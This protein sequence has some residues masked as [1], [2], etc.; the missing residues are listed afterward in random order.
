MKKEQEYYYP[1]LPWS[2]IKS[3]NLT[4]NKER[5][6]KTA[7]L[8]KEYTEVY[9]ELLEDQEIDPETTFSFVYFYS[10]MKRRR[11]FNYDLFPRSM[12]PPRN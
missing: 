6:T 10:M 2:L 7:K 1:D 3:Y 12:Y 5:V 11:H 9:R 8:L 4:F